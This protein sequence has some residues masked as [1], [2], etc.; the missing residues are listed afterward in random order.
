VLFGPSGAGKTQTL[1]AIAGLT[2]PDE[3]EIVIGDLTL[4][5]RNADGAA[6]DLP[7]RNRRVGYVTQQYALFPHM[8]A[9]QNVSYGAQGEEGRAMAVALMRRL[10]IDDLTDRYPHELSGGQQQRVAIARALAVR[11]RILLL[12]EPF[13]AL[14]TAVRLQLHALIRE[15]QQEHRLAVV[16]V[17]HNLDDAFSIGHRIAIIDNGAIAQIGTFDDVTLRPSSDSVLRI[18]GVQNPFSAT[19]VRSDDDGVELE[20]GGLRIEALPDEREVGSEVRGYIRGEDV[21]VIQPDRPRR[22]PLE[23]NNVQAA[24]VSMQR[25]PWYNT[26]RFRLL[27]TGQEIEISAVRQ[28]HAGQLVTGDEVTLAIKP[29]AIVLF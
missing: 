4:F 29:K 5:R 17:T 11:P 20:W 28:S 22:Y 6:I 26:L 8:T 9:L 10:Q 18:L 19:V 13:A 15:L 2:T 25:G 27:P 21:K 23:K 1:D 16:Y 14:D 7:A 24:L 3:G 12:D